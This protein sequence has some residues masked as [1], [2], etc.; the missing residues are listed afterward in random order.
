MIRELNAGD[1]VYAVNPQGQATDASSFI[2]LFQRLFGA[3]QGLS[4]EAT[5]RDMS[6]SNY[7]STRQGLIEDGMTYVEDEE[8]L[9]EVMDEI[10]ETFVISVVLAGLIKAPVK[11][12]KPWID[13]AKEATATK[14]AL[15]TGQKTFKQIAAENGTDWKTQVDDIAEVLQYAKEEHG[16][17]LGGVIL[18]QAVQQQ[19]APAQ[20]TETPAAGSGADSSTPGKAE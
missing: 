8:L 12:P 5:S 19:T 20:Q 2:K 17:D 15:Q 11:D 10:Y 16:I 13:P 3:G 18:G 14:I 7:S 4:Y 9:L 6:Q 1:D